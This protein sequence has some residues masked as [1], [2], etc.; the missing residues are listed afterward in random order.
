MGRRASA[1]AGLVAVAMVGGCY[2]DDDAYGCFDP[3]PL[4]PGQCWVDT[5]C[6]QVE[7]HAQPSCLSGQCHLLAQPKP[8]ICSF[9]VC[10]E[11]AM[12]VPCVADADCERVN[13]NECYSLSCG[14][15]GL[16]KSRAMQAGEACNITAGAVC[17]T[18]AN[19]LD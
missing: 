17:G 4:D 12:C 13:E 15:D 16:C 18:G 10:T 3:E 11:D 5:D 6:P 9:G 14:S 2:I 7:C 19:C 8:T 1:W